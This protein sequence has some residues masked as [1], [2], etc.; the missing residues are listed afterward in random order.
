[1]IEQD[2]KSMVIKKVVFDEH[3]EKLDETIKKIVWKTEGAGY[4]I[5]EHGR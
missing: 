2:K 5:N 4:F 3:Q 1:M